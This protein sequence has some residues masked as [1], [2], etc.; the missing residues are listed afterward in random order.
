M[1]YVQRDTE[2]TTLLCEECETSGC[3]AC[4]KF[5][6][7]FQWGEGGSKRS[8]WRNNIF[9]KLPQINYKIPLLL[10]IVGT[11][12]IAALAARQKIPLAAGR[13]LSVSAEGKPEGCMG[14]EG[15][16]IVFWTT[17]A[18][19]PNNSTWAPGSSLD[20]RLLRGNNDLG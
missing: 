19:L 5:I 2:R 14:G 3:C 6:S 1:G 15:D 13:L 11:A 4:I 9:A 12:C 20:S 10:P 7:A 8:T 17:D 16:G 18:I